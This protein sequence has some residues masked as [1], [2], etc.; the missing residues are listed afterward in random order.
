[1]DW[2]ESMRCRGNPSSPLPSP[3][4][5]MATVDEWRRWGSSLAAGSRP[6]TW[7][8]M[9]PERSTSPKSIT[10]GCTRGGGGDGSGE[11]GGGG[12]GSD[13]GGSNGDVG[14]GGGG[15]VGGGG[16]GGGGGGGSDYIVKR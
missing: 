16:E 12:S 11:G 3:S 15:N 1:M 8:I 5:S 7:D 9:S 13:G 10:A 2:V 4:L 14:I 6:L